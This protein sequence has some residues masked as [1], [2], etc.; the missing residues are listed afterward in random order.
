MDTVLLGLYVI[1]VTKSGEMLVIFR[2]TLGRE[3]VHSHA[4]GT[5][6]MGV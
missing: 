4:L 5:Q 6:H 3:V 1:V 2:V